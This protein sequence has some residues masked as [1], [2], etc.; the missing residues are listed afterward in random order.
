[1]SSAHPVPSGVSILDT[2]NGEPVR[3][4]AAEHEGIAAIEEKVPLERTICGTRPIAAEGANIVERTTAVAAEARH[5]QFERGVESPGGIIGTPASTLSLPLGFGRQP[6]ATRAWFVR[7][8][9]TL[10]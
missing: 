8:I 3:A 6:V 4:V 1:M 5:R 10:P 9:D 7:S 2:A